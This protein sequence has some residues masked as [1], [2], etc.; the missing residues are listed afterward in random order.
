M[1]SSVPWIAAMSR[2]RSAATSFH[3]AITEPV[4]AG[5]ACGVCEGD[6]VTKPGSIVAV[7]LEAGAPVGFATLGLYPDGAAFVAPSPAP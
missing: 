3:R 6:R 7:D 4:P 5:M 2:S 1:D